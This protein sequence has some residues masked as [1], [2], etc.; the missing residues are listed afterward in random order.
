MG[1]LHRWRLKAFTAAALWLVVLWVFGYLVLVNNPEIA[2]W[3]ELRR[4]RPDDDSWTPSL[5]EVLG[6]FA[7]AVSIPAIAL[8]YGAVSEYRAKRRHP[9]H[10]WDWRK[11]DTAAKSDHE[12]SFR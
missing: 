3:E 6:P 7:V 10:H 11:L 8:T 9:P 5:W 2:A 12:P 1:R 4:N